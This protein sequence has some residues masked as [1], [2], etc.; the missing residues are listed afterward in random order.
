LVK[1]K[2][3]EGAKYRDY[4]DFEE[5]L[6]D[7]PSHR[8]LA[9][10]R[11]ENEG[12]IRL[13]ILPDTENA[14][15]II[16]KKWVKG[17]NPNST[18]VKNAAKDAYQRLIEPSIE[19]EIRKSSKEK[20]DLEAIKVFTENLGQLLLAPPLGQMVILAIDPG[21]RTGC[22]VVVIDQ[23]GNL[24]DKA[25]IF[26]HPPQNKN[27]EAEE[28]I[29]HLI[30]KH[31]VQAIA[32]GNGTA[33]RE[34]EIFLKQIQFQTT[35][36]IF[37]VNESGA[38][39]YSASEIAR[40]E[41]PNEDIT[42][43]GAVSIG[44]RLMDP[45]AELIKID[46]KSIGVGQYQHD[47]NQRMLKDELDQVVSICVNQVGVNLNT[48]GKHLLQYI[49][50]LGPTLAENIVQ[51]R[52]E[53][54]SFKAIKDLLKVPRMGEKVFEQSAGFLRIRNGKNPLDNTGVHPER[55]QLVEQMAL[56][57]GNSVANIIANPTKL[58]DL[59]LKN[60][61]SKEVGM[62]T[63]KDILKEIEKPG[64]DPRGQ[65]RQF[66]FTPGIFSFEDIHEGMVVNGLVN[67][68][69][70]FGAFVDIGIK[71]S[72]LIHIS[73]MANRFIKNPNEV[74]K[75]DQ[76][77]AVKIIEIDRNRKR[78]QLSLKDVE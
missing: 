14:Q 46:P 59:Q 35:P 51:Y 22:K 8:I 2:E 57:L 19:T 28:I 48:A 34:T 12:I 65:A 33:G 60:Y 9:L 6:K 72:G 21:F 38:S 5:N 71:E 41:L 32:V 13:S 16:E 20:A 18:I 45:L 43:R 54:G 70:N 23:N 73:N 78:I 61:I 76:E 25:T 63:L 55:Y 40:E 66:S 17:S 62:P 27:L 67:N 77:V 31:Q 11:A 49:S 29:A 1:G 39:I 37:M 42:V 53:N 47:V 26:P 68:I 74:V 10:R 69:T 56:D 36:Q 15:Y 58:K 75:L 24:I 44:R 4:F 7:S 50:G 3:E 52:K 64:L 30:E